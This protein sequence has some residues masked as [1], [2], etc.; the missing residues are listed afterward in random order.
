[1]EKKNPNYKI[2]NFNIVFLF[3]IFFTHLKRLKQYF[4]RIP[5]PKYALFANKTQHRISQSFLLL[6]YQ[7]TEAI[8][9]ATNN[10]QYPM[11]LPDS[12]LDFKSNKYLFF[13]KYLIFIKTIPVLSAEE[14]QLFKSHPIP[15]YL[16]FNTDVISF[17]YMKS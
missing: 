16:D 3:Q 15:I 2:S 4:T 13:D 10:L 17:I 6:L 14:F 1:M 11:L 9:H 7:L 5:A 12:L 8:T